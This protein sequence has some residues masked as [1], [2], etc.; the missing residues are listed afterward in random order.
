MGLFPANIVIPP[1]AGIQAPQFVVAKPI[2]SWG[3][4]MAA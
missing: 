1:G 3:T 2:M 4:A